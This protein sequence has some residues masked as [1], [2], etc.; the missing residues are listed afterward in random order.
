M[1]SGYS[2][3]QRLVV[4]GSH[5]S[6]FFLKS[7]LQKIEEEKQSAIDALRR[8]EVASDHIAIRIA[9]YQSRLVLSCK[10]YFDV[11]KKNDVADSNCEG[12]RFRSVCNNIYKTS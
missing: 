1:A 6:L 3:S 9:T 12:I 4:D 7:A 11:S 8:L 2:S 10:C 5:T